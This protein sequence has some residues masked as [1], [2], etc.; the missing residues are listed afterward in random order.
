MRLLGGG[1]GGLMRGIK[2]PQYKFALKMQGGLC[3]R[4]G[5]F[6][7]HYGISNTK[8]VTNVNIKKGLHCAQHTHTHTHTVNQ[9][10]ISFHEV[11]GPKRSLPKILDMHTINSQNE[12]EAAHF[13]MSACL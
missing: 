10:L 2:I 13:F 6:A 4:G 7:G 3:A 11:V 8:K 5:V 9:L 12:N 1:G